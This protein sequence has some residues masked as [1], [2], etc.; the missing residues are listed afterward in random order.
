MRY[1]E[2]LEREDKTFAQFLGTLPKPAA[3]LI[4]FAASAF[5]A[6]Y[7]SMLFIICLGT[8]FDTL[9][10]LW[11]AL[12]TACPLILAN[13]IGNFIRKP[14]LVAYILVAV[15][16]GFFIPAALR[17]SGSWFAWFVHGIPYIT[18]PIL[19]ALFFTQMRRHY[20]PAA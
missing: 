17:G 11:M 12:I 1:L 16:L 15:G 19:N 3:Y 2:E 4:M 9:Q 6:Y 10:N 13:V 5:A 7:L 8:K 14:L 18:L 20:R